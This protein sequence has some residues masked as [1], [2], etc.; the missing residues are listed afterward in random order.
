MVSVLLL[1]GQKA[2]SGEVQDVARVVVVQERLR[3]W[4]HADCELASSRVAGKAGQS[5]GYLDDE[6][7]GRELVWWAAIEGVEPR[8]WD[9][10]VPLVAQAS[11]TP[12][13][14]ERPGVA[15][16][17][18]GRGLGIGLRVIEINASLVREARVIDL[19]K[20]EVSAVERRFRDRDRSR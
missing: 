14:V 8:R 7:V 15:R 11:P 17:E 9:I 10:A 1:V 13:D 3:D 2:Q 5:L 4:N 18:L 19:V 20:G 6:L 12:E 16:L